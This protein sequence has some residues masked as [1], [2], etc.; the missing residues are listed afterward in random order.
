MEC[1]KS[2]PVFYYHADEFCFSRP[3]EEKAR[4]TKREGGKQR[5]VFGGVMGTAA[6]CYRDL[7]P[8]QSKYVLTCLIRILVHMRRIE[9]VP[10]T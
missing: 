7:K 9:S 2:A 10:V 5:T 4:K 3:G 6:S 1:Y 8:D